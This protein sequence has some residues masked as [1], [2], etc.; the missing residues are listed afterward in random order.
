M[1][2]L[3]NAADHTDGDEPVRFGVRAEPSSWR[4]EVADQGGGVPPGDEQ[5]VFEPFS[6]GSRK[7]GMGLGLSIVRGIAQAHGGQCGLANRPG[8]GAAFWI[9]IPR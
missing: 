1:N 3:Q 6:T 5:A 4:F 2:L 7:G 8:H 9:R